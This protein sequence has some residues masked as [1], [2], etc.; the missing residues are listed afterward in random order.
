V[1]FVCSEVNGLG[2]ELV[3]SYLYQVPIYPRFESNNYDLADNDLCIK[4][5]RMVYRSDWSDFNAGRNY[6][7]AK[8][9]LM[10]FDR[11]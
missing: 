9:V 8:M 1:S 11:Y 3:G 5:E 7:A 10:A 2:E 6:C 4:V